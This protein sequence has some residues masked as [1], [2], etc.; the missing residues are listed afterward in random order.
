MR[1]S[2]LPA[3]LTLLAAAFSDLSGERVDLFSD[4]TSLRAASYRS[5][6]RQIN[7]IKAGFEEI[8]TQGSQPGGARFT[9]GQLDLLEQIYQVS[10]STTNNKDNCRLDHFQRLQ[11]LINLKAK[12]HY[13]SVPFL[14]Y[15]F[16]VQFWTCKKELGEQLDRTYE[17]ELSENQKDDLKLLYDKTSDVKDYA[18]RLLFDDISK[19]Q[20]ELLT[21]VLLDGSATFM[22]YRN[23]HIWEIL[24]KHDKDNQFAKE[25]LEIVLNMCVGASKPM[26][27]IME[28]FNEIV[29]DRPTAQSLD[30]KPARVFFLVKL[31]QKM[32]KFEERILDLAHKQLTKGQSH[33]ERWLLRGRGK[34]KKPRQAGCAD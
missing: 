15:Y 12:F 23:G 22:R 16:W 17:D 24:A 1:R 34:G 20:T 10:Q 18:Y 2:K 9:R 25:H 13:S 30:P 14:K 29:V 5:S 11:K 26:D 31:C 3:L 32:I 8:L 7:K 33:L 27:E 6:E 4:D 19:R 28:V 21:S